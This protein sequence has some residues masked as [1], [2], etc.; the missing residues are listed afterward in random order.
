MCTLHILI[1][2]EYADCLF[3]PF[4]LSFGLISAQHCLKELMFL[5]NTSLDNRNSGERQYMRYACGE[6]QAV[7]SHK[8]KA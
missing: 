7:D 2:E 3:E 1:S 8:I 4:C 5:H 6:W